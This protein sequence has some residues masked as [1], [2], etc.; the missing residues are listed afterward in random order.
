[1]LGE[2]HK[3]LYVVLFGN[4]PEKGCPATGLAKSAFTASNLDLE[5]KMSYAE[6]R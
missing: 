6:E 5:I 4:Y 2:L 1:M 3:S